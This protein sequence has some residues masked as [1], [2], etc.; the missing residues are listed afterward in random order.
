[1]SETSKPFGQGMPDDLQERLL[2]LGYIPSY[3]GENF[4]GKQAIGIRFMGDYQDDGT[5]LPVNP[6]FASGQHTLFHGMTEA[7]NVHFSQSVSNVVMATL[8]YIASLFTPPEEGKEHDQMRN[9]EQV[10]EKALES[11][12]NVA[13]MVRATMDYFKEDDN[14]LGFLDASFRGEPTIVMIGHAESV[15]SAVG[16]TDDTKPNTL[17]DKELNEFLKEA[18]KESEEE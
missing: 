8:N 14:L 3:Q 16:Y 18:T 10:M 12:M 9:W 13:T 4:H 11:P 1:M 17:N 2:S 7:L 5:N 6:M 15:A